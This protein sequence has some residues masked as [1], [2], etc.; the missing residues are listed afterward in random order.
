MKSEIRNPKSEGTCW[1]FRN[2]AVL[3][4]VLGLS[5]MVAGSAAAAEPLR[6]FIRAGAKTHGPNQH[7]HPRFL[8]EWKKLLG[9]RSLKVDG[10]LDFPSAAQLAHTDVL[11]I[12]AADGM[13]I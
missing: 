12:Y 4:V 8:E 11:I 1:Q 10:A 6:V 9:E 7:D 13:K 5:L 2:K 3:S